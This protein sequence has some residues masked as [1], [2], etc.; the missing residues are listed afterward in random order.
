MDAAGD[1]EGSGAGLFDEQKIGCRHVEGAAERGEA[2][3]VAQVH[4]QDK[5]RGLEILGLG[6]AGGHHHEGAG[7]HRAPQRVV[8]KLEFAAAIVGHAAAEVLQD[9]AAQIG[10]GAGGAV[11]DDEQ[12][13]LVGLPGL[14]VGVFV[15]RD[16]QGNGVLRGL[17]EHGQDQGACV[18]TERVE[19][20]DADFVGA[21]RGRGAGDVGGE[22]PGQ[23][24]RQ[25]GDL[26]VGRRLGGGDGVGEG[27][28]QIDRGRETA[29]Q[30]G[31][32][33]HHD[34]QGAFVG[35]ER[36]G[37]RNQ[38]VVK[39]AARG[40]GAGDHAGFGIQDEARGQGPR[41]V[42]RGGIGGDDLVGERYV[43]FR[44]H[45]PVRDHGRVGIYPDG[46]REDRG[47]R[48][49]AV[50]GGNSDVVSPR[51]GG[52]ARDNTGRGVEREAGRQGRGGERRRRFRR[53]D[54]MG[55]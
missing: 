45:V 9:H 26:V 55:K 11:A 40:R 37:G 43:E 29:R 24:F 12:L 15:Y 39:G 38:D 36:V 42:G 32:T 7:G 48:S 25:A 50:D 22:V 5:I 2:G 6:V 19:R 8:G 27:L 46:E 31:G 16:G 41:G 30:H 4:A 17:I 3:R 1:A 33:G 54:G 13:D 23:A 47:P 49:D 10:G 20:T 28:P 44:G 51:R 14:A 34:A 18:G 21:G 52:G 53:G 35:A